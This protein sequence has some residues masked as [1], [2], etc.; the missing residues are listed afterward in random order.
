MCEKSILREIQDIQLAMELISLG[1]RLQILENETSLSRGRLLKLYKELRG[2][3]PPKGMLPFSVDWFMAW[4]QNIHS[5]MFYN[6]Y[7]YLLK[8]DKCRPIEAIIKAYRLY[9]EQCPPHNP[10][11]EPVLGLTR[12]WTLLRFIE[13][14]M[15]DRT[16]C[17]CC[18]GAFI[19]Y[20]YQP[21]H[22][23]VCSLCNPPSRAVKKSKL[24]E[25]VADNLL[26]QLKLDEHE[27]H[28]ASLAL[29]NEGYNAQGRA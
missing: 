23:F 26:H 8:T 3:P 25:E 16:E 24:S 20:S 9:L 12:A 10:G 18:K 19:V 27:W 6:I 5:S 22:N 29:A 15:L 7:L 13:S 17:S 2:A 4:E 28:S 11:E 14:G 1:A 21:K